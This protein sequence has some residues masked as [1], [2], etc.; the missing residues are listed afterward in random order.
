MFEFENF[1][2]MIGDIV[3]RSPFSENIISVY[4]F[5]SFV[6]GGF[7][8]KYSDIDL[9]VVIKFNSFK[10]RLHLVKE[11]EIMFGKELEKILCFLHSDANGKKYT[12]HGNVY[13]SERE[14]ERYCET[15]PT[16]VIYPFKK[17]IWKVAYGKD[18]F[19]S[20]LTPTRETCVKQLQ[21]DYEVFSN[22]FHTNSF[23][24]NVRVMTKY[25]LRAIVVAVWILKDEYVYNKDLILDKAGDI[26]PEDKSLSSLMEKIK[27]LKDRGY[28]ISGMDYMELYREAFELLESY[29]DKINKY[30]VSNGYELIDSERM[31]S[32]TAWENFSWMFSKSLERYIEVCETGAVTD[33]INFLNEDFRYFMKCFDFMLITKSKPEKILF[34]GN[35]LPFKR[36]RI[37]NS[38][39]IDKNSYASIKGLKE[40]KFLIDVHMQNIYQNKFLGMNISDLM[41]YTENQYYP[42]IYKIYSN[43]LE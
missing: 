27:D 10:E 11:L 8:K 23:T 2:N 35:H 19:E 43:L 1:K 37:I 34:T 4:A 26:F 15:Y 38:I 36:S 14:F 31:Y 13:F 12:N 21:Y 18:Y 42:A 24:I 3:E 33:L 40:Y 22:G 39:K 5:G 9:W 32:S 7:E 30:V 28:S 25:I 41:V 16:R 6:Q 20:C 29:G 17:G